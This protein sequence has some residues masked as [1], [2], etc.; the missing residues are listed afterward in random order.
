MFISVLSDE[1]MC[2]YISTLDIYINT[3]LSNPKISQAVGTVNLKNISRT[4][5]VSYSD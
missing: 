2:F 4:D 1:K 3:S 5:T